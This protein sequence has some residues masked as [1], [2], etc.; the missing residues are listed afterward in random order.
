MPNTY[1][2]LENRNRGFSVKVLSLQMPVF[3]C[4][5]GAQGNN[6][7]RTVTVDVWTNNLFLKSNPR[8]K[9]KLFLVL[10]LQ[11]QERDFRKKR[12]CGNGRFGKCI[13][14]FDLKMADLISWTTKFPFNDIYLIVLQLVNILVQYRIDLLLILASQSEPNPSGPALRCSLIVN[15]WE[16]NLLLL[17]FGVGTKFYQCSLMRSVFSQLQWSAIQHFF[18][19]VPMTGQNTLKQTD[20]TEKI[21]MVNRNYLHRSLSIQ[22]V[23]FVVNQENY[24]TKH[25]GCKYLK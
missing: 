12:L 22:N 5:Y 7:G 10:L 2:T 16:F 21:T 20:R 1:D 4:S 25:F 3:T 13:P 23:P 24:S 17:P 18:H 15:L 8:Y 14:N 19:F 6:L 11:V 9:W